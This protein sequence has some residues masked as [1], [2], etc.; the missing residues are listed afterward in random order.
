MYLPPFKDIVS[1][2]AVHEVVAAPNAFHRV[3]ARVPER[4]HRRRCIVGELVVPVAEADGDKP[5]DVGA[6]HSVLV[7]LEARAGRVRV[8][9]DRVP[10]VLDDY[11]LRP[12]TDFHLVL[13]ARPCN[14]VESLGKG[15]LTTPTE[16]ACAGVLPAVVITVAA[17]T[18]QA[19]IV[20]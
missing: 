3:V 15:L 12:G 5:G 6:A 1:V 14:E 9:H 17:S 8:Y 2:P 18:M 10:E 4:I 11:A 19:P 13:G 20:S 7:N 16:A